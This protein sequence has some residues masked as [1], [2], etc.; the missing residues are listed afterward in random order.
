MEGYIA[1]TTSLLSAQD[2]NGN[3][4]VIAETAPLYSF[5]PVDW[6]RALV[7][8][9]CGYSGRIRSFR[10]LASLLFLAPSTTDDAAAG[11][12]AG[13][14]AAVAAV[15]A[16]SA[17]A[18]GAAPVAPSEEEK[19]R[20]DHLQGTTSSTFDTP[21]NNDKNEVDGGGGDGGDGDGTTAV[22]EICGRG[23]WNTKAALVYG[24]AKVN[25]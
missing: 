17:A 24:T 7:Q 11:D 5:D 25:E 10:E 16:A 2:S 3:A 6:L 22:L 12:V 9:R 8:H 14:V 1:G 13:E 21:N 4:R 15:A 20:L 18:N 23:V 19:R